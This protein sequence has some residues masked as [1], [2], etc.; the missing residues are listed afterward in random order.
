MSSLTER[1]K[2]I[3]LTPKTEWPVIASEPATTA[4]LFQKYILILAAVPAIAGFIKSTFLGVGLG[5]F[6]TFRVGIGAGITSAVLGFVL[7]LLSVYVLSLIINALAPTFSAQKDQIQA[8]KTAAYSFTASWIAGLG[9][10]VPWLGLLIAIAGGIYSIYL[11]HIGL[12]H[13]MKVPPEKNVGYTVVV[14]IVAIVLGWVIGLVTAGVVGTGAMLGGSA[15]G[16]ASAASDGSFD[17]DS[18]LGKLEGWSKQ[19]EAAGKQ[20]EQ[21]QKS[22]DANAQSDAFGAVMAAAMGGHSFEALPAATLKGFVPDSLAGL[23]RTEVS[24][25]RNAAMGIQIS[26]AKARYGDTGRQLRLE[27]TDSAG[28]AG[29]MAFAGWANIESESETASGFER[30]RKENG[31]IVHEQWNS[32]QK[33]GEYSAVLGDRFVVKVAGS[34][35]SLDDLESAFGELDL[36]GLE[37][38]RNEGAKAK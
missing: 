21:A 36:A 8:L 25:E 5:P 26:E 30:T 19:M 17:K 34:A 11:L 31:R 10:L 9:A 28:A 16:G 33:E 14:V 18:P 29:L 2:N 20:M 15:L 3:L 1:V 24:A 32:Q 23:A 12:P 35:G 27:I 38:L 13:T 22:G 7:S 4:G 6:G 37:A